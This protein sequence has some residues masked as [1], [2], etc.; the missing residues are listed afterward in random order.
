MFK[1]GES[2]TNEE[3]TKNH[4]LKIGSRPFKGVPMLLKPTKG[5]LNNTPF[6]CCFP[7]VFRSFALFVPYKLGQKYCFNWQCTT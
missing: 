5:A 7:I 3:D 2:K 4:A 6:T 1:K